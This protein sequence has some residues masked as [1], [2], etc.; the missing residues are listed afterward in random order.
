MI[1]AN[2]AQRIA[3]AERRPKARLLLA[4]AVPLA[5]LLAAGAAS[6]TLRAGD[7]IVTAE[8]DFAPHA[9]PRT[10]DAPISV[11]GGGRVTTLSGALPPIL[12]DHHPRVRPPRLGP[13]HGARRLH[14][15]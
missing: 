9:L 2:R 7:I 15:G 4:L 8:G 11:H 6:K 10:H 3:T 1:A 13:D 5:L 14:G 12:Q